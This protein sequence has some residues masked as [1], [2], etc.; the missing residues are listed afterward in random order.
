MKNPRAKDT[1]FLQRRIGLQ[2]LSQDFAQ[3]V[4]E[5]ELPGILV[6]GCP[7]LQNH[8]LICKVHLPPLEVSNLALPPP[9]ELGEGDEGLQ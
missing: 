3:C 7:D 4:R 8:P 9:G 6:L 5:R 1:T 2:L